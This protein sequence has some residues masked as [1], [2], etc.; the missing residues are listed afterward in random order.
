L[1]QSNSEEIGRISFVQ[2]T[3]QIAPRP[4]DIFSL[5]MA[6]TRLNIMFSF[7]MALHPSTRLNMFSLNMG[8]MRDNLVT[9]TIKKNI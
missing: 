2:Q 8:C 9:Q 3:M 5:N 6:F 7:N 1:L 4:N